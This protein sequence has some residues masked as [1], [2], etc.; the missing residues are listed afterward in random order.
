MRVT[1]KVIMCVIVIGSMIISA[2]GAGLN[3][4]NDTTPLVEIKDEAANPDLDSASKGEKNTLSENQNGVSMAPDEYDLTFPSGPPSEILDSAEEYTIFE[5]NSNVEDIHQ[6]S[7]AWSGGYLGDGVT[8]A[9]VDTGVD[10]GHMDLQGT[11]A[12]SGNMT[13]QETVITA[14]GDE[15]WAF[16][17]HGNVVPS[18]YTIYKN[19]T[20]LVEGPSN[21]YTINLA[22]GNIS[23]TTPL[24]F[25]EIINATYG[26]TPSHYGWPIAFDPLSMR[27]FLKNNDTDGTWYANTSRH[28]S[29]PF[30]L[31]HSIEI[32][33]T[34]DF[35]ELTEKV[36]QDI[37]NNDAS[38]EG[39]NKYDYDLTDVYATR[40][41]DFWYMGFLTYPP[42]GPESFGTYDYPSFGIYFDVDNETSG[43]A[44]TDPRG[45]YVDTLSSH[46]DEV[47]D[48]KYSPDGT[49]VATSS[50][51][52][53]IKIWDTATGGCLHTFFGHADVPRSI[54]WSPDSALLASV[55]KSEMYLWN[56]TAG[57]FVDKM[58]YLEDFGDEVG[59]AFYDEETKTGTISF[60]PNGTWVAISTKQY[61]YIVDVLTMSLFGKIYVVG[62]NYVNTVAFHSTESWIAVG[63]GVDFGGFFPVRVYDY[64][65]FNASVMNG[66]VIAPINHTLSGHT[67]FVLNLAWHPTKKDILASVSYGG[68]AAFPSKVIIWNVTTETILAEK[69]ASDPDSNFY[70]VA[71]SPTG[72]YLVT[73]ESGTIIKGL[74]KLPVITIRNGTTGDPETSINGTLPINSVDFSP[75]GVHFVTGS[76]DRRASVW[77]TSGGL[78][79]IYITNKP[80][81][82][83]YVDTDFI[84]DPKDEEY[85]PYLYNAT[86]YK[87]NEGM[88]SWDLWQLNN[89]TWNV[90]N[91]TLIASYVNETSATFTESGSYSFST[92]IAY[93]I[94]KN[95]LPWEE[96]ENYSVDTE[97]SQ[98]I[99]KS[100][101]DISAGD[102]IT[103]TYIYNTPGDQANFDW[104]T[105][106]YFNEFAIPRKA[107]GD[108]PAIS[109]EVFS[110]GR[111]NATHAQDTTPQDSGIFDLDFDVDED[112]G[113]DLDT[114]HSVVN[115]TVVASAAAAQTFAN[116]TYDDIVNTSFFSDI[117]KKWFNVTYEL[118][119]NYDF[120]SEENEP[121]GHDEYDLNLTTGMITFTP[122]LAAGDEIRANYSYIVRSST[123]TYS[124]SLGSFAYVEIGSYTID[125][126]TSQSSD[127]H[128]GFHPSEV[129][130]RAYGTLG[131]LVVDSTN[132]YEYEKVILDMNNDHVFDSSDVV[133][134]RDNPIAWVDNF[135][136]TAAGANDVANITIPDGYPDVSAGM[137]Y[138]ISDGNNSIPY[139]VRYAEINEIEDEDN[140]KTP[141]NGNLLAFIGEFDID[142]RTNAKA[143][144]G[145]KMASRLISQGKM[146]T[147]QV[148]GLS[149]N[150]KIIAIGG[151]KIKSDVIAS[152]YFAV[153]GYDGLV[154]TGDEAQIVVNGFNYPDIYETGWDDYSRTA[155]YISM[156][157]AEEKALFVMSAGDDGY[158][159]GTVSSPAAGPG[160]LTVGSAFDNLRTTAQGGAV[161]GYN[162]PHH[163]FGDVPPQA[164]RGPTAMGIPKPDVVAV[165][166]GFVNLPLLSATDGT[167]AY[168]FPQPMVGSDHSAAVASSIACLV[169]QAY[170]QEHSEYPSASVAKRLLMSGAD[171]VG[172]DT[173]TQGAGFLNAN[174]S[175]AMANETY[176]ISS[177][178]DFWV[179]GDYEGK[180]YDGFASLVEGGDVVQETMSLT[181]HGSFAETVNITDSIFAKI[182]EYTF[183]NYTI[184]NYYYPIT[185]KNDTDWYSPGEIVMWLNETGLN[186]I[187]PHLA[188]GP[189]P[190]ELAGTFHKTPQNIVPP[191][192]GLWERANMIRV[193]AYTNFSIFG[194]LEESDFNHSYRLSLMDWEWN[195]SSYS[196]NPVYFPCPSEG[197]TLYYPSDLN[198]ISETYNMMA[199]TGIVSNALETRI[200][201]PASRIHDGL[202]IYL[203][204]TSDTLKEEYIE[205][206]FE[207]EFFEKRDW[208]WLSLDTDELT[209]GGNDDGTFEA[210]IYVPSGTGVGSYSG[211]ISLHYNNT[212][213]FNEPMLNVPTYSATDDPVN[214]QTDRIATLSN[215]NITSLS[216]EKI[217]SGVFANDSIA[218]T[219]VG[220]ESV[221][222][223]FFLPHGSITNYTY[224]VAFIPGG[225]VLNVSL[226]VPGGHSVNTTTGFVTF[227]HTDWNDP[228]SS[229]ITA[230]YAWYEYSET[231]PL[232]DT[233]YT[234]YPSNGTIILDA[235][236]ALQ[237]GEYL[238]ADYTWYIPAASPYYRLKHSNIVDG[239]S[240]ITN[241]G[242]TLT[243]V[244]D[245]E[246]DHIAGVI[247]FN[248]SSITSI[249]G[250]VSAN[251]TY[252]SNT[253]TIPVLVNV[254]SPIDMFNYGGDN[255]LGYEPLYNN[256]VIL[257]GY[258]MTLKS[259]S[260][261]EEKPYTGDRR[262]FFFNIPD[263]GIYH[264]QSDDMYLVLEANWT[265][266]PSDIDIQLL[267]KTSADTAANEDSARYGTYT[268]E[269]LGG[270]EE[271]SEPVFNTATN[272]SEEV[273]ALG[274][275]AGLNVVMLRGTVLDGSTSSETFSGY[276]CDVSPSTSVD[277]VTPD[278]AGDMPVSFSSNRDWSRLRAS[279]VGPAVTESYK[280]V[281]IKQDYEPWWNF[282]WGE[283][284]YHGSYTKYINLTNVLILEVHI[285]GHDDAPDLDLAVFRDIDGDGKV[286][287]G[288]ETPNSGLFESP[289]VWMYDADWDADETVKWVAPPDGAYIIKVIG[290]DTKS[291]ISTG[292]PGGHFDIDIGLTLDTGKGYELAGTNDDDMIVDPDSGDVTPIPAFNSI[293]F[294]IVWN[295]PGSTGD[296]DYGGAVLLGTESA[297]GLIVIPVTISL[298]RSAPVIV[299]VGPPDGAVID[300]TNPT[301]FA[302]ITDSERSEIETARMFI[303][304]VEVTDISLVSVPFDDQDALSGYPLGM[305]A[306]E[307]GGPLSEGAHRID[308][309]AIDWAGNE[310]KETWVFTVD[311]TPAAMYFEFPSDGITYVSSADV[312]I[313]GSTET[314]IE[315]ALVGAETTGIVQKD[316]GSFEAP[317]TLSPGDNDIVIRTT[318]A[319]GNIAEV[320]RKIVYDTTMPSISSL[321]STEG[322]LTTADI[323]TISG[324]AS[325]F[326]TLIIGGRGVT[327][328]SDGT[329][330][331]V[332]DLVEG[333]NTI[334]IAF[335]DLAGNLNTIWMSITKDTIAP[336][337]DVDIPTT[338]HEGTLVISGIITDASEIFIN[339]KIP[340]TN[341]TRDG[342]L[343]FSK[344][345]ALSY[346]PN[347]IV[348]EATDDAGNVVEYRHVVEYTLPTKV[349]YVAIGLMVALLVIGLIIGLMFAGGLGGLG[350]GRE[351][352][353]EEEYIPPGERTEEELGEEEA[354]A[355][356]DEELAEGEGEPEDLPVEEPEEVPAGEA[357]QE[358]L[359]VEEAEEVTADEEIT[360]LEDEEDIPDVDAEP[361]PEEEAMPE[362]L[363]S[364]EGEATP[365]EIGD[366]IIEEEV[367]AETTPEPVAEEPVVEEPVTEEPPAETAVEPD[368]EPIEDERIAKLKAAFEDGKISQELYEKNLA[369]LKGD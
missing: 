280:D 356:V 29:G 1:L 72:D 132:P 180:S 259:G 76:S 127:F 203:N 207:I 121:M 274:L 161:L 319:A 89:I 177:S 51:D 156:T 281:E 35:G 227:T 223:G 138:F 107:F 157:H 40:D 325:E 154:G 312:T 314:G 296:G 105:L 247:K 116:L 334:E 99:I 329:F 119:K 139:S 341:M 8:M 16:L 53:S 92:I 49:M 279:A 361:I 74:T 146:G 96:E 4:V 62:G 240:E 48:V 307:P 102:V 103:A 124:T 115:E 311:T 332:V 304:Y 324:E 305:I 291:I 357:E 301:I 267:S 286:T 345:L 283:C 168:T 155:D 175:V 365:E 58:R 294:D 232:A 21:D 166:T 351:L 219:P 59:K 170:Y 239:T 26:Y 313:K 222:W 197:G 32:D 320:N 169:Y 236:V 196:G 213:V 44:T 97:L 321:R 11:Q 315:M 230:F 241:D 339:G 185:V 187:Y 229:G 171:D 335:T 342:N 143:D 73:V 200:S 217:K 5:A 181:N 137:L 163:Y 80:D 201:N 218:Y 233:N 298:D 87:W 310:E 188:D 278:A 109:F 299:D 118:Y 165:N 369:R 195:G 282:P 123:K 246:L 126:I 144:H 142:S 10:F 129:V 47:T 359:A 94:Y 257:S 350:F 28:G 183:S 349:N 322:T 45:N 153:E 98:I 134:D 231:S 214:N 192:Y 275:R 191:T 79:E 30:E 114:I 135:N 34:N 245:Y 198:V 77:D 184:D 271:I 160:T 23:F 316:D 270:S 150:A 353:D 75:D 204:P 46:S 190:G 164:S 43:T 228:P 333:T 147:Y 224:L 140:Y 60:S 172:Y 64:S 306:Y 348:I 288:V 221:P 277:V 210:T 237:P 287:L 272:I 111:D 265:T 125:G 366:Q 41:Q 27:T 52:K 130:K 83:I 151:K 262:F 260:T 152:W 66:S 284:N 235:D 179:P 162:G 81:Y 269:T 293:D 9:L 234:L 24:D 158:G 39:G 202:V 264:A 308:V 300:D 253:I 193:T 303:D 86:F 122:P 149:P 78:T 145:T 354:E 71:W 131:I 347:T 360:P 238:V 88:G 13:A 55:E 159:Y 276:S 318:D 33:G 37:R 3:A 226:L 343:E 31:I 65:T 42:R 344:S 70:G 56:V 250:N 100:D 189:L 364:E 225:G 268:L 14:S 243:E 363:P 215:G 18:S 249:T 82:A 112:K 355:P 263:Q 256:S 266:K 327:V 120:A 25:G 220:G 173:L 178:H 12:I 91:E 251:Y 199:S 117:T 362:D 176:G 358:E 352:E 15:E 330:E 133:V 95:G 186:K 323:T 136:K 295:F 340:A 326:G 285:M 2:F 106:G 368:G 182:G 248:S 211:A 331:I 36:G 367:S 290:F 346:G 174:R 93:Q 84:W 90:D 167:T 54:D 205:W 113:L 101:V 254:W 148:T 209:I 302:S 85:V 338:V 292:E 110:V 273:V 328:N 212:S 297:P 255:W 258:D 261:S 244:V 128:F 206:N 63:L 50:K 208:D 68:G 38:F 20:P 194:D 7:Q 69:D 216:L 104:G 17:E 252:Y 57:E 337:I 6:I 309:I 336:G 108:P 242:T 22:T 61:V 317:V 289:P 19:S 67:K 141:P